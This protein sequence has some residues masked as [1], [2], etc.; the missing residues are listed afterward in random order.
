MTR[1][2]QELTIQ[3]RNIGWLAFVCT[4]DM[5]NGGM[6][7]H[8]LGIGLSNRFA[9]IAPVVATLFGDEPRPQHPVS[10]LMLNGMLDKHVPEQ[11]GPPGGRFQG[12][13]DGTLMKPVQEQSAFRAHAD[14]CRSAADQDDRG[15]FTFI[16]MQYRCPAGRAV[17][18]YWIKDGDHA[19]PGG[20]RASPMG[21]E[22]SSAINA[23]E[24]IWA[25][26]KAH[27]KP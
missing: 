21:D 9:A 6:M 23:T 26:F 13:W 2:N 14:G 17:E 10:A 3:M 20:Q 7:A 15:A 8:R 16:V 18:S 5:S 25:F 24:L 1:M 4:T 19:W 22:P 12:A 11:G 27:A